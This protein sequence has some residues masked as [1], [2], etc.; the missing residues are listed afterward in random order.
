M[1]NISENIFISKLD[2]KHRELLLKNLIVKKLHKDEI[3]RGDNQ[4]CGGVPIILN[5]SMALFRISENGKRVN[6]YKVSKNEICILSAACVFTSLPYDFMAQAQSNC[7]VGIIPS[8]IF[9]IL[10][11]EC[12]EFNKYIMKEIADK[13][14][15]SLNAIERVKFLSVQERIK[16]YLN[17]NNVNKIVYKTHE[18]IA[19]DIGTTRETV[20][21]ELKKMKKSGEIELSRGKI[22]I[23]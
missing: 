18:Q 19:N 11:R 21:R 6:I 8:N 9:E 22:K 1:K 16:K 5:G 17:K 10:M 15:Y 23:L 12:F 14:I 2:S 3:I 7:D 20:S 4:S 13:L